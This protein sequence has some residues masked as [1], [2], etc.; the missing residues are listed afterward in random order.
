MAYRA[1]GKASACSLALSPSRSR[2]LCAVCLSRTQTHAQTRLDN[3]ILNV[4]L[5]YSE[6]VY[7]PTIINGLCL[8]VTKR[9]GSRERNRE[10][11]QEGYIVDRA[12]VRETALIRPDSTKRE[13]ERASEHA[14]RLQRNRT[15]MTRVCVPISQDIILPQS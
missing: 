11:E 13:R 14:D 12:W 15:I 7:L 10:G 5:L 8:K 3:S 9:E 4:V 1:Q 6:V 2:S